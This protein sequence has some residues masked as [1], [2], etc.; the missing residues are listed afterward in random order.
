MILK[1]LTKDKSKN[2]SIVLSEL[3]E[4]NIPLNTIKPVSYETKK[5]PCN[6]TGELYGWWIERG[7][8]YWIVRTG[9]NPLPAASDRELRD[10]GSNSAVSR[11]TFGVEVYNYKI[12][13]QDTLQHFATIVRGLAQA[14]RDFRIGFLQLQNLG[15]VER[16]MKRVADAGEPL[17]IYSGKDRDDVLFSLEEVAFVHQRLLKLDGA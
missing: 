10:N 5:Y 12:F 15:R 11:S 6:Y 2:C 8:D 16:L 13:G 1:A 3:R 7:R 17:S 4:A 9:I 14:S